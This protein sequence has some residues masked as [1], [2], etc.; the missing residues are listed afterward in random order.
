MQEFEFGTISYNR[1]YVN[2][3]GGN[4]VENLIEISTQS[5]KSLPLLTLQR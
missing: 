4:T 5:D 2:Y 1:R 3:N